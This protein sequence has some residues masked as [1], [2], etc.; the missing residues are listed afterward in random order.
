MAKDGRVRPVEIKCLFSFKFPAWRQENRGL[1]ERLKNREGE[2]R[3][4]PRVGKREGRRRSL[5]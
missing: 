2:R 4:Y 1:E 3:K 5:R